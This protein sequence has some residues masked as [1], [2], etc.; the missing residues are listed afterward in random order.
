MVIVTTV[1]IL[2]SSERAFPVKNNMETIIAANTAS[3]TAHLRNEEEP[4]HRIMEKSRK[5]KIA[6][7]R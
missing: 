6:S 5:L 2:R 4:S 7:Q 1:R 3:L